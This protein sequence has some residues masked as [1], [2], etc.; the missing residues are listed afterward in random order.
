MWGIKL[1]K[2]KKKTKMENGLDQ[3]KNNL[4]GGKVSMEEVVGHQLRMLLTPPF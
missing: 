1:A 2:K 4:E 3:P